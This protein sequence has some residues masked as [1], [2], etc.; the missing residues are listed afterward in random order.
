MAEGPTAADPQRFLAPWSDDGATDGHAARYNAALAIFRSAEEGV[1]R[2]EADLK[3]GEAK[4]TKL[5]DVGKARFAAEHLDAIGQRLADWGEP[6]GFDTVLRARELT[7]RLAPFIQRYT[8]IADEQV[9]SALTQ[10]QAKAKK[11]LKTLQQVQKLAEQGKLDE[12]EKKLLPAYIDLVSMG[13]WFGDA[14]RRSTMQEYDI[15]YSKLLGAIRKENREQCQAACGKL[16]EAIRP[17]FVELAKQLDAVSLEDSGN[18]TWQDKSLPG[19]KLV[20]ALFSSLETTRAATLRALAL[21]VA[22]LE[23]GMQPNGL[24]A[25]LGGFEKVR[26]ATIAAAVRLIESDANRVQDADARERYAAY[27]SPVSSFCS[28]CSDPKCIEA[29]EPGLEKLAARSTELRTD[30]L[31]YRGATHEWLRWRKRAAAAAAKARSQGDTLVSLRAKA[32][33]QGVEMTGPKL[34]ARC[35][36]ALA[37][38]AALADEPFVGNSKGPFACSG[39]LGAAIARIDTAAIPSADIL[40]ADLLVGEGAIP[41]TLE[42]GRAYAAA[43]RGNLASAAGTLEGVELVGTIPLLAAD[44]PERSS[45]YPADAIRPGATTLSG[46]RS[47][48]VTYLI[49]LKPIWVATEY[50]FVELK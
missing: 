26:A 46:V 47:D 6:S 9:K 33:S 44:F 50:D 19:P 1:A 11:H 22:P 23:L 8:P 34:L 3:K 43:R 39:P 5:L 12:A 38:K 35:Q 25:L 37:G 14:P 15:T 49:T 18:A 7:L 42:A 16:V 21:D 27:L 48:Q 10:F 24:S 13:C 2:H 28:K 30:I 36:E 4:A 32:I 29:F 41:L 40:A 20:S 31:A 45:A 17:D